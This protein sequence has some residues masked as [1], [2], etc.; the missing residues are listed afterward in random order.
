MNEQYFWAIKTVVDMRERRG[1]EIF[2]RLI[3]PL[4]QILDACMDLSAEELRALSEE[5]GPIFEVRIKEL[6]K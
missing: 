4:D 3:D 6:E 5:L 1:E 2:E